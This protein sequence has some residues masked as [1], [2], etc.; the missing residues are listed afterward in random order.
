MNNEDEFIK[1]KRISKRQKWEWVNMIHHE[2]FLELRMV[3]VDM[4]G[5]DMMRNKTELIG[6]KA[7]KRL[8][9]H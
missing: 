8:V 9:Y 6:D 1:W 2:T 4:E 5:K 7:R 3:E